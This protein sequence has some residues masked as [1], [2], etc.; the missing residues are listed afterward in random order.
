MNRR[1]FLTAL[2]AELRNIEP[3]ELQDALQ[4]YNEYFDEAGAENEQAVIAELGTP[5]EIASKIRATSAIKYMEE[6]K[7]NAKKSWNAVWISIG[8][9]FAAP[10]ALPLALAVAILAIALVI[11]FGAIVFSLFVVVFLFAIVGI[12]ITIAS[13][14]IIPLSVT[15]FMVMFGTGLTLVGLSVLLFFPTL[16]LTTS[17]FKGIALLINRMISKGGKKH[18]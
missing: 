1:D 13:F 7:P 5:Q 9:I 8:T 12:F 6:G 14:F 18:D 15:S 16:M 4:Y 11:A 2:I 3:S 10:I 17:S